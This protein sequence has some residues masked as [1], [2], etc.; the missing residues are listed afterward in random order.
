[1]VSDDLT[2]DWLKRLP[3]WV[4]DDEVRW[5]AKRPWIAG[6]I[7][8]D[9]YTLDHAVERFARSQRLMGASAADA[10]PVTARSGMETTARFSTGTGVIR[11]ILG[12]QTGAARARGLAVPY[13]E[14]S[15]PVPVAG[16]YAL[17]QFDRDSFEP[18]PPSAPLRIDHNYRIPP[19]GRVTSLRHTRAGVA[20]EADINASHRSLWLQRW[21]R[22]EHSSLSIGFAGSAIFDDWS[23]WRGYP[24]RTVRNARLIEISVVRSPAYSSARI[25]ELLGPQS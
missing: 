20:I 18:L 25:I 16:I 6:F 5:L 1:M 3:D 21:A 24:L 22:G 19:L 2:P 7:K 10:E 14:R 13:G 8:P 4:R 17:E 15:V 23:Q 12:M 11:T 9:D